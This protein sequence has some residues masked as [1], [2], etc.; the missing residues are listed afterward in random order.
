MIFTDFT[1]LATVFSNVFLGEI[2]ITGHTEKHKIIKCLC[3]G[4]NIITQ[5]GIQPETFAIGILI[6]SGRRFPSI[7]LRKVHGHVPITLSVFGNNTTVFQFAFSINPL[8][9]LYSEHNSTANVFF[10]IKSGFDF[11]SRAI[12]CFSKEFWRNRSNFMV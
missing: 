3:Y 12:S 4:P 11:Y 5:L 2:A 6:S 9:S 7:F 1:I 8:P 10:K